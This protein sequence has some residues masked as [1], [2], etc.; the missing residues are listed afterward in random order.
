MPCRHCLTGR[1]VE[2]SGIGRGTMNQADPRVRRTRKLLQQSL[3]DLLAEKSFHSISVQDVVD[4]ATV[5][6]ATFYAHFPDKYALLD[7]VVGE[8]FRDELTRAELDGTRFN[9]A[10]LRRLI[11]T[12]LTVVR[13]F[14]GGCRPGDRDVQPMLETKLQTVLAEFLEDWL[15]EAAAKLVSWTVFGSGMEWARESEAEDLDARVDQI[16]AFVLNGMGAL[17]L[18]PQPVAAAS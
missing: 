6:R 13:M 15:G 16:L 1:A 2:L 4:R 17:A 7:Y 3:M 11:A 9:E 5:N 12:V 10:K 14:H 8:W 18:E